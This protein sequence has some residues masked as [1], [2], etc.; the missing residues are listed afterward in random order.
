MSN[1]ENMSIEEKLKNM[2]IEE[3]LKKIEEG[4]KKNNHV[5]DVEGEMTKDEFVKFVNEFIQSLPVNR[6]N[7]NPLRD[8]LCNYLSDKEQQ[9]PFPGLNTGAGYAKCKFGDSK[10]IEGLIG[11]KRWPGRS[12]KRLRRRSRRKS[13]RRKSKNKK[14]R[15]KR[16]RTKKKRRRRR[17]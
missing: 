3:I 16:K 11:G 7:M 14:R 8:D 6:Y 5:Q 15:R 12:Q 4:L 1:M 17:C 9:P 10:S 13:K 2:S